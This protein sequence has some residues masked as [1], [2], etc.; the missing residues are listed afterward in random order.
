[1]RTTRVPAYRKLRAVSPVVSALSRQRARPASSV[2]TLLTGTLS[3]VS[4]LSLT[5]ASPERRNM[6]AGMSVRFEE[7][8]LTTSPG[9]RFGEARSVPAGGQR[10]VR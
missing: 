6:S 1:M 4:M 10:M 3:P 2:G 5:M 9:T 7:E 8:R